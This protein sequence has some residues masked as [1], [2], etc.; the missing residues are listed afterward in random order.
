MGAISPRTVTHKKQHMSAT[1]IKFH[2]QIPK[3]TYININHLVDPSP[4]PILV[5]ATTSQLLLSLLYYFETGKSWLFIF[6][7]AQFSGFIWQWVYNISVEATYEGMHPKRVQRNILLGMCFFILSEIMLFFSFFWAFFSFNLAPSIWISCTWPPAQIQLVNPYS[8]PLLN[9]V[10]LLSSGVS[11]TCA[12]RCLLVG[13]RHLFN[14]SLVWTIL[15]GFIFLCVQY[16]EY[17]YTQFT[18]SDSVYGS[19]FYLLTGF[20]GLHVFVGL[21]FLTLCFYA[22]LKRNF[23]KEHHIL[24]ICSA[25]YWHFVD[26]VWLFLYVFLYVLK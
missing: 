9:T 13:K 19:I 22:S 24:F 4:W 8:L 1:G 17:N 26:I 10:L 18:I 11:V 7:L 23:T 12:H 15:Y 3:H 21:I 16:F 2:H 6:S 25:W 5:A 20:H 14:L